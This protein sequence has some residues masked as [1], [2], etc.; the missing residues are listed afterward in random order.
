MR[1]VLRAVPL[2]RMFCGQ[3]SE[4]LWES[5]SGEI[6]SIFEGEGGEQGDTLMPLLYSLGQH[7][8]LQDVSRRLGRGEHPVCF[9]G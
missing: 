7:G 2:V 9:F 4:Y 1:C 5:D 8:A 3:A 6:H